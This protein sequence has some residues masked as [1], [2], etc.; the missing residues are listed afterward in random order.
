MIQRQLEHRT[1]RKYK[2]IPVEAD[3]LQTYLHVMNRTAA[4]GTQAYSIIHVTDPTKK[5]Q[6]AKATRQPFVKDLPELFVFIIDVKRLSSITQKIYPDKEQRCTFDYFFVGATDIF[7]AAQNM[8]NAIESDGL[9]GVYLS[10]VAD[11]V[12]AMKEILELPE[13]TFPILGL[14]FG[15]P[16]EHP[17]QTLWLPL[18][19]KVSENVYQN[20]EDCY[21]D[22]RAYDEERRLLYNRMGHSTAKD[23]SQMIADRMVGRPSDYAKLLQKIVKEGFDLGLDIE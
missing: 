14:G 16:D 4:R 6:I 18:N 12:P 1:I 5:V 23:Y 2:E 17:S 9:G 8:M 15:Y 7:L 13:L 21:G 11:D 22:I 20:V 10:T 3:K 19:V